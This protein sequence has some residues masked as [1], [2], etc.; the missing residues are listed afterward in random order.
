MGTQ[1]RSKSE[2]K[3]IKERRSAEKLARISG[4]LRVSFPAISTGVYG[5]PLAEAAAIALREAAWHPERPDANVRQVIFVL[6]GRNA[7]ETYVKGL[8]SL[9]ERRAL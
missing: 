8:A 7:Y 1:A 5:Y 3:T 4:E 2:P 6:F 9:S